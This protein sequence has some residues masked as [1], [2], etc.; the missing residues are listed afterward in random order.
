MSDQINLLMSAKSG[1][2]NLLAVKSRADEIRK[3]LDNLLQ[4]L[5]FAP[6]SLQWSDQFIEQFLLLDHQVFNLYFLPCT[7][8]FNIC[9]F[10]V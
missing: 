2:M 8:L 9:H 5:K 10:Q 7:Y 4:T 3:T 6:A 1:G